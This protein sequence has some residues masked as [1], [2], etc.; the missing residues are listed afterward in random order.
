MITH[1]PIRSVRTF[2]I[3]KLTAITDL[4]I[5]HLILIMPSTVFGFASNNLLFLQ[6]GHATCTSCISFAS[7]KRPVKRESQTDHWLELIVFPARKFRDYHPNVA[8]LQLY[9]TSVL[10]SISLSINFLTKLY[11]IFQLRQ[12]LKNHLNYPRIQRH[13][14]LCH[15]VLQDASSGLRVTLVIYLLLTNTAAYCA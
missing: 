8:I 3:W 1:A 7:R 9:R 11:F 14:W 5:G 4:Q 13:N 10:L 15:W 2:F 6:H 12:E